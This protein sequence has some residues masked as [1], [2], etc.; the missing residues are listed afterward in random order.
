[1]PLGANTTN[2]FQCLRANFERDVVSPFSGLGT[3]ADIQASN[4][5]ILVR[6][7]MRR[8]CC[9]GRHSA[10]CGRSD[11]GLGSISVKLQRDL[12][13]SPIAGN[14]YASKGRDVSFRRFGV[15]RSL[16]RHRIS[17]QK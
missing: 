14:T 15:Y 8:G 9:P 12:M 5:A 6:F 16:C 2:T 4:R 10:G 7:A 1:M 17:R 3:S 11:D 13:S